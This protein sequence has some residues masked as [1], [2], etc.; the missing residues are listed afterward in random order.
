MVRGEDLAALLMT[1]KITRHT[2]YY[3]LRYHAEKRWEGLPYLKPRGG[4]K[5]VFG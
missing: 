3:R 2:S 5:N 1:W 4:A